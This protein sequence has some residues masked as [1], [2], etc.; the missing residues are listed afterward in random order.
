M[1]FMV[2]IASEVRS[3]RLKEVGGV[4]LL[5]PYR[6]SDSFRRKFTRQQGV[7]RFG[8]S[9]IP[10]ADLTRNF[11]TLSQLASLHDEV[12]CAE[13]PCAPLLNCDN[14]SYRNLDRGEV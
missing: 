13:L 3:R 2:Q 6:G 1:E 8:G 9:G 10:E 14:T 11:D 5:T 4:F 7:S 12:D